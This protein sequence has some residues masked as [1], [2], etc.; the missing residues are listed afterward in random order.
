MF[1]QERET[2]LQPGRLQAQ[3]ELVAGIGVVCPPQTYR[4]MRP[5]PRTRCSEVFNDTAGEPVY[6]PNA[7]KVTHA[8]G[9]VEY[10]SA[11]SFRA[12][13]AHAERMT[14]REP[15]GAHHVTAGDLAPI[16]DYEND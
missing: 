9:S 16:Q 6:V 3:P 5:Q 15:I 14:H 10:R 4:G 1:D 7:V 8:D 13:R 2:D 11:S 12:K